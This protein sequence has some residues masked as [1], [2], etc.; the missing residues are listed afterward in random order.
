MRPEDLP[1]D[2]AGNQDEN[3]YTPNPY[4]YLY[5]Y[6]GQ[7]FWPLDL[8]W[9][10]REYWRHWGRVKRDTGHWP[11]WSAVFHLA[12]VS[13]ILIN[14]VLFIARRDSADWSATKSWVIG[15]GFG[16][17]W[18]AVFVIGRHVIRAYEANL[19]TLHEAEKRHYSHRS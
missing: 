9:K 6:R 18:I 8:W 15:I 10:E 16:V 5:P 13:L 11:F 12:V 7:S 2:I 17:L 1:E 14:A 4:S 19:Y 3:P